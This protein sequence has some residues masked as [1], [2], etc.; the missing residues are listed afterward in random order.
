MDLG[1][2]CILRVFR[3]EADFFVSDQIM[4]IGDLRFPT[5]ADVAA[6]EAARFRASSP[7]D[8]LRAIRSTLAGGARL[9]ERSPKRAFIEAY[10][11][12][13]EE[14]AREAITRFV[15]RHAGNT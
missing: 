8:R 6:E 10:R 14:L 11:Q 9:I 1:Q 2:G 15:M 7:A 12:R 3:G 5:T 13:Q 4:N